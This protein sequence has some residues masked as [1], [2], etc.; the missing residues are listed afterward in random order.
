M[1]TIFSNSKY[2]FKF[3]EYILLYGFIGLVVGIIITIILHRFRFMKRN[4]NYKYWNIWVKCYYFLIPISITVALGFIG[5][6][7]GIENVAYKT[8]LE[9]CEPLLVHAQ[10]F[11][12]SLEIKLAPIIQKQ[13][14]LKETNTVH[15]VLEPAINAA[16]QEYV[17]AQLEKSNANGFIKK[18]VAQ[19]QKLVL[20]R[21]LKMLIDDKIKESMNKYV[22]GSDKILD[23]QLNQLDQIPQTIVEGI[24]NLITSFFNGYYR[25]AYLILFI[26]LLVPATDQFIYTKKYENLN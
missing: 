17:T 18:S 21:L 1:D 10:P 11:F 2:L 15:D 9:E 14:S 5:M 6:I 8:C 4:E 26:T 3:I 22:P 13:L 19:I 7:K 25:M 16:I 23:L 24:K 20:S 12:D